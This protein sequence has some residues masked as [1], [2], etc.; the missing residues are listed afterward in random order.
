LITIAIKRDKTHADLASVLADPR[1]A[2]KRASARPYRGRS[3]VHIER[4]ARQAT[5]HFE[6]CDTRLPIAANGEGTARRACD[7][8]WTATELASTENHASDRSLSSFSRLTISRRKTVLWFLAS[9]LNQL[10]P[11]DEFV[12]ASDVAPIRSYETRCWEDRRPSSHTPPPPAPTPPSSGASGDR[13]DL[14]ADD[15]TAHA[16]T[17]PVAA[18]AI[19]P[20]GGPPAGARAGIPNIRVPQ[21]NKQEA[22][23][24]PPAKQVQP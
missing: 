19:G 12:L 16:L 5:S 10:P 2:L 4:I 23:L 3:R 17:A 14:P 6:N 24:R 21:Q 1:L 20:V 18:A 22:N 13:L 9:K 15:W 11:G 8:L 7:A